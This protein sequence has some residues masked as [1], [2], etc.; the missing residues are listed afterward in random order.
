MSPR[1]GA[2]KHVPMHTALGG[3]VDGLQGT[4]GHQLGTQP[5]SDVLGGAGAALRH[6]CARVHEQHSQHHA[7]VVG[8]GTQRLQPAGL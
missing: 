2:T 4:G 3:P 8:S 5:G 7:P 6:P 1:L